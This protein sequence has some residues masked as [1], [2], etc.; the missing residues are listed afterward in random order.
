MVSPPT[1]TTC[2]L[3]WATSCAP[4]TR[5]SNPTQ[6]DAHFVVR[7]VDNVLRPLSEALL[8]RSAA[9]PPLPPPLPPPPLLPSPHPPLLLTPLPPPTFRPPGLLSA[10]MSGRYQWRSDGGPGLPTAGRNG[11]GCQ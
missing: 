2:C 3:A 8:A 1:P 7:L 10:R 11:L 5:P 4:V 9:S 6:G